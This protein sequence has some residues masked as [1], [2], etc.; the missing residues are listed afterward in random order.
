MNDS[1]LQRLTAWLCLAAAILMG[2]APAGRLVLCFAP[3]GTVAL[4]GAV[5]GT[6][7]PSCSDPSTASEPAAA[8]S[9]QGG[10]QGCSCL[11]VPVLSFA[12]AQRVPPS[13]VQLDFAGSATALFTGYCLEPADRR[14]DTVL[15][16]PPRPPLDL[17]LIRSV[18]LLV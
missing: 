10:E 9:L 17:A 12:D 14:A 6:H 2:V 7:C 13:T 3:N 11:D 8:A 18:V 4:E 5:D 16:V 1:A 15:F